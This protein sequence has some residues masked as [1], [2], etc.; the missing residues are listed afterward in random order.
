[1]RILL[2]EDNALLRENLRILLS[3][4][5]TVELVAAYESAEEALAEFRS[6]RPDVLLSD[7]DLPGMSGVELIRRVKRSCP[8]MDIM[9]FTI[10][11]DRDTVFAAI[12]A[13]ASG[14][15][16]KGSSPRELLEALTS[17]SQGGAPM[18][19][20]IARKV[21]REF[22][23]AGDENVSPLSHRECEILKSIEQGLSYKE[24]SD[25]CCISPHTVHTHIKNI[26]EKLQVKD[27]PS[28]ILKAR[29]K[30]II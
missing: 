4:E 15:I 14:Y 22:Q 5:S 21:I 29:K 1:M 16:L 7:L 23:A 9:A 28:A 30:G 2:V 13:G 6:V 25:R 20:K 11:E 3:G 24:I 19:P 12:K 8:D 27:R 10:F 18:S 26:Y 17:L